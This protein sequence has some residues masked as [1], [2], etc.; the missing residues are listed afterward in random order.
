MLC[1]L[2]KKLICMYLFIYVFIYLFMY[3][4]IYVFIY[5]F[6]YLLTYLPTY[7]SFHWCEVVD[8]SWNEILPSS[9]TM[10]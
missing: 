2:R 5:L 10:K 7:L 1:T 3:L 8:A 4:C 6:I 9:L